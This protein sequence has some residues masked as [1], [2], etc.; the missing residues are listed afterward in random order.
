MMFNGLGF[1]LPRL[2]VGS[3]DV[4][5]SYEAMNDAAA[6]VL[7]GSD[8]LQA[9]CEQLRGQCDKMHSYWESEACDQ[10]ETRLRQD[11]ETI[12]ELI[13]RFRAHAQNLQS[14]AQNYLKTSSDVD[15]TIQGLSSDV[16]V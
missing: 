2:L 14:I 7:R 4:T 15:G 11:V 3:I 1:D 13:V 8:R 16:I 9:I 12:E 10:N 5:V 6:N